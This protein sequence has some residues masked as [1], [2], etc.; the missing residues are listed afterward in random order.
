M[1]VLN[2]V[3]VLSSREGG[4]NAERTVQLSRALSKSGESCTVL[5][6]DIGDPSL[7]LCQLGGARLVLI[8]CINKRF[9]IPSF[10]RSTILKLVR[11]SDVIHL[12]GY[13][14]LLGVMVARAAEREGVPYVISPAGALSLFGRSRWLKNFFNFC[15]GERLL[16]RAAGWIAVTAS[17]LPEFKRYGIDPSKVVVIPNGVNAFD[18]DDGPSELALALSLPRGPFILFMGRL[19]SIKGPDLLLEA[20][21]I[22]SRQ[23]HNIELVFAGPDEGLADFLRERA[24]SVGLANR[25]HQVGFVSGHT[26]T[27]MYRA[28]TLLVV[29]SRSEAMSIVA[30]EAG[31]C[32][33]PVLMTDQCGLNAIREV[34]PSLIVPVSVDS[35]ADGLRMAF[36]DLAK[37]AC[38][39][40]AWQSI[41][42]DRFLWTD[43]GTDFSRYLRSRLTGR[44][45]CES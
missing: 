41:V 5:T 4:G 38:W 24:K 13:W 34:T 19:N 30:V 39:G 2:V 20:F 35:L 22:L 44:S 16:N 21:I 33:T 23:F 25:V 7:R 11:S 36:S 1:R 9:Q 29:P 18:F 6:L 43:I 31:F 26:K 8:S 42:R 40:I 17:E 37:L 12:M 27:L 3:S 15:L 28:A 32:G 14:S 45:P 10:E